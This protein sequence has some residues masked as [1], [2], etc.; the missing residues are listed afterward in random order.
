MT[1][2]VLKVYKNLLQESDSDDLKLLFKIK[3]NFLNSKIFYPLFFI[4]I[5]WSLKDAGDFRLFII[6]KLFLINYNKYNKLS[7]IEKNLAVA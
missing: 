5:S 6:S 2:L 4:I 1:F 7:K 3:A